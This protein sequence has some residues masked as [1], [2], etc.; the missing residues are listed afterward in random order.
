M[1]SKRNTPNIAEAPMRSEMMDAAIK[2]VALVTTFIAFLVICAALMAGH[3]AER[4]YGDDA[5]SL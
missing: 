2:A 1:L 4:E 3:S 5:P